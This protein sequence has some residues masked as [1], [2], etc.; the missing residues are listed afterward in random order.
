MFGSGPNGKIHAL[1]TQSVDK[2]NKIQTSLKKGSEPYQ[3]NQEVIDS[4]AQI[5]IL[6]NRIQHLIDDY[7]QAGH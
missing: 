3:L 5:M 6:N 7:L 4:L 1:L 2:L